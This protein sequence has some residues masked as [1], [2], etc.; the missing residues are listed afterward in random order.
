MNCKKI[1]FLLIKKQVLTDDT[2]PENSLCLIYIRLTE[3]YNYICHQ[4]RQ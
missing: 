1:V 4:H 2:A 3:I